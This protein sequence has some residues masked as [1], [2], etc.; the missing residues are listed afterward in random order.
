MAFAYAAGRSESMRRQREQQEKDEEEYK[1]AFAQWT[2]L[3][4]GAGYIAAG[5]TIGELP[6]GYYDLTS[7]NGAIIWIPL[8]AH[9]QDLLEFPDSAVAEVVNEIETFWEREKAF[10]DHGL[11]F[12]RG[13]LLWGPAG[14]GKT[15]SLQL[16]A[17]DVVARGGVVITFS[18][19]DLF[20]GAYR[21]LRDIQPDTPVVVLME[22]IDALIERSNESAILN[23]L[24]GVE[25]VHKLVFLATT[26]F[27]ER[28]G[29]RIVN[30]PSRF[31]RRI[32][33]RHP[34]AAS[35]KMYLETLLAP[36]DDVDIDRMVK[37]T[38]GLSL[39]HLKELFVSTVILKSDY[40]TTV[41]I[42]QSMR[43][44]ADSLHDEEEFMKAPSGQYV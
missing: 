42:L 22:D 9:T 44:K 1:V 18:K 20:I 7:V 31:D 30:R 5:K 14:S 8:K 27:P 29:A 10:V 16:L 3:S 28:L 40:R 11:P 35:R 43:D 12:K 4:E 25:Q 38:E 32:K 17:R 41:E 15:S 39:A 26:N 13:I 37:D 24:D 6:P 19:T 2:E 21:Q 23:L 34:I 33:I 36:D